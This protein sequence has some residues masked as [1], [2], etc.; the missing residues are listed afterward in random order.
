MNG[1][2]KVKQRVTLK[3]PPAK[4]FGEFKNK[5]EGEDEN[6]ACLEMVFIK[7]IELQKDFG[8]SANHQGLRGSTKHAR[9]LSSFLSKHPF[10]FA[11]GPVKLPIDCKTEEYKTIGE[12]IT[13]KT[14]FE[15]EDNQVC[16]EWLPL[17]TGT[18]A[19]GELEGSY[20]ARDPKICVQGAASTRN[21][22]IVYTCCKLQCAVYC[23]CAVCR[24]SR[25]NC[26]MQCRAEV[27]RDCS[28]QCQKHSINIPRVFNFKTDHFTLVTR[29]VDRY[30]YAVPYAGI[31][32]GCDQCARDVLEHQVLHLVWH[33]RC[34][35]CKFEMRPFLTASVVSFK[36]YKSAV[37]LG[38][39]LD[40][41]SCALCKKVCKDKH[42]RE[43]HEKNV[44]GSEKKEFECD[45][46]ES[47]YASKSALTYHVRKTHEQSLEKFTCDL[48]GSQ[49]LRD[50]ELSRHSKFIHG[51]GDE[52]MEFECVKCMIK[53]ARKD[54][55]DRH[56]REQHYDSNCNFA[57]VEN[58]DSLTSIECTDCDQTFKRKSD[59]KRH[60]KCVHSEKKDKYP[61][62][63]CTAQFS[64]K[65]SLTRHVK[66]K[67]SSL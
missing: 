17:V 57:Y 19:W 58:L 59:L 10:P 2:T 66:T 49:F 11:Q 38:V 44:H 52:G 21:M 42:A 40:D 50:N 36:D 30:Q 27:C 43:A 29:V 45:S 47:S 61:C 23:P 15:H 22:E 28:A 9:A 6:A 65:D 26:R 4:H 7:A 39:M 56:D 12:V 41:R 55:K 1:L 48:C 51:D 35:F 62:E 5:E 13:E 67:H 20:E 46:C 37:K 25:E 60:F 54:I 8:V 18:L 63:Q 31:P 32:L 14:V 34:K 3:L 16:A 33:F 53:F 64:R 24:D